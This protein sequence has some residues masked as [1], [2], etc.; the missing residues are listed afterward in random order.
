MTLAI[1]FNYINNEVLADQID[2]INIYFNNWGVTAKL[3][4]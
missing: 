2:L 3:V 1:E 4:I